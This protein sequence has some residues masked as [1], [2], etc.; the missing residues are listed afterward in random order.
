M[1]LHTVDD[2]L[3]WPA[4][5]TVFPVSEIRLRISD[6]DYP[7]PPEVEAAAADNWSREIAANPALFNGRMLFQRRLSMG[8]DTIA[9]EGHVI[10]YATYLWWRRQAEPSFGYHL[11]ALPVPVSSDGAV[12][13]VR[14]SPHTANPGQV[15]CAAGS[16]EPGDVVDGHADLGA[17]MAREVMEE[18]GLDLGEAQA[19]PQFYASYRQRRVTVFRLYR[20]ALTADEMLER[21]AAHMAVD[22]EKEISGAVAIRSAD[23]QAHAYNRAMLPMLDW[24]FN[25]PN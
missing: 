13:A 25:R 4:E 9:G 8:G 18:T 2:H 19:D 3:H 5:E 20:F 7:F 12:I 16:L 14:M 1:T 24:Y 23:P 15:Y 22:E 21:I 17:N 10:P 6:G 11:F